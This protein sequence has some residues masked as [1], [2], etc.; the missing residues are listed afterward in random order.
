[1]NAFHAKI[2]VENKNIKIQLSESENAII[3]MQ[4]IF[5]C[6]VGLY[7]CYLECWHRIL[8]EYFKILL[9]F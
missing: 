9:S 3:S 8:K 7:E 5:T 4:L 2:F 1:M 6:V